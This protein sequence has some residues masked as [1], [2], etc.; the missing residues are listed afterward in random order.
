MNVGPETAREWVRQARVDAGTEPGPTSVELGEIRRLKR[1][2]RVFGRRT[3]YWMRPR[4]SSR[5]NSTP[6]DRIVAFTD[7]LK[8]DGRGVESAG[9]VLRERAVR[10]AART[11]RAWKGRAGPVRVISG[12]VLPDVFH[13]RHQRDAAG[14]PEP[15]VSAMGGGR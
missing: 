2:N 4:L 6:A 12:A 3:R 10:V 9:E 8:A 11:Y 13:R 14:R 1:G 5:G 15:E 7:Q